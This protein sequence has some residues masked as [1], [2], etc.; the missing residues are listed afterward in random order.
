MI[1]SFFKPKGDAVAA[2]EPTEDAS[3]PLSAKRQ[4]KLPD[5]DSSAANAAASAS[6]PTEATIGGKGERASF[7]PQSACDCTVYI[8]INPVLTIARCFLS[9]RPPP[10]GCDC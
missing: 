2:T 1:T 5:V 9:R 3:A 4:K 7:L 10:Q 6:T 8:Y